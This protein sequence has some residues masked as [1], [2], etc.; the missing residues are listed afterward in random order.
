MRAGVLG[1][2]L[3]LAL[4]GRTVCIVGLGAV[5]RALAARLAP[6]RRASDRRHPAAR[7]GR[8]AAAGLAACYGFDERMTAFAAADVLALCLPV[9]DDTRGMIDAAAFAA[10]PDDA[11]V[12]NVAR[13]ALDRL[14]G[15]VRRAVERT[16][17]RRGARR[18]LG[19]ADCA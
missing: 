14:R 8:T 12:V 11:C 3:G 4:T 19:G 5:G 9:T 17:A 15:G 6:L 13:G 2:P 16:T 18:V 10:L 7:P 1:A